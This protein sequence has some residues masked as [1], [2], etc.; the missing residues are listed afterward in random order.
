MELA[1][2]Y[3][4]TPGRPVIIV[5]PLWLMCEF[6]ICRPTLESMAQ[7]RPVSHRPPQGDI[8]SIRPFAF[9]TIAYK[10]V[11]LR[12]VSQVFFYPDNSEVSQ[13]LIDLC[14]TL[15]ARYPGGRKKYPRRGRSEV[16][17]PY[18][19]DDNPYRMR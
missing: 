14:S 13:S 16:Q 1:A 9:G 10:K 7:R 4:S 3:T 18:S 17:S 6:P 11:I 12:N 5:V 15:P 2:A 8:S 19:A